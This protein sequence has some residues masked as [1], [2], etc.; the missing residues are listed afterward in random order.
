[1]FISGWLTY[2]KNYSSERYISKKV[3]CRILPFY[4]WAIIAIFINDSFTF[5]NIRNLFSNLWVHPDNGLWFLWVLALNEICLF[6][7]IKIIKIINTHRGKEDVYNRLMAFF[8]MIIIVSFI[9]KYYKW[10]GVELCNEYLKFFLLGN[11]FSHFYKCTNIKITSR[12]KLIIFLLFIILVF[13]WGRVSMPI[14]GIL[15]SIDI[16]FIKLLIFKIYKILV[17][18]LGIIL[19]LII[20]NIIIKIEIIN[21]LFE[22]MGKYTIGIY[23]MHLYFF[24]VYSNNAIKNCIIVCFISILFPM[25]IQMTLKY[26]SIFGQILFGVS[27]KVKGEE[28]EQVL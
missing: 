16:K 1:M 28:N 9:S 3:I 4:C 20:S 5:S 17:P 24:D 14:E 27:K 8:I 10:G 21:R 11:V 22:T 25:M 26:Y 7:S 15:S 13:G 12:F 6:F 19:I 23:S 18:I 2:G